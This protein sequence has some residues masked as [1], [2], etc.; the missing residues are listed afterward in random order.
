MSKRKW[1]AV[2]GAY[3]MARRPPAFDPQKLMLGHK[4]YSLWRFPIE[5]ISV[6]QVTFLGVGIA[7]AG[8]SVGVGRAV[9]VAD[10]DDASRRGVRGRRASRGGPAASAGSQH[11]SRFHGLNFKI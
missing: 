9:A 5:N 11:R 7:L 4:K 2:P 8:A 1:A 10:T 3:V 6:A